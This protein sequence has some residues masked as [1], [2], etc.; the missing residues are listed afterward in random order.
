MPVSVFRKRGWCTVCTTILLVLMADLVC[1]VTVATPQDS[2]QEYDKLREE[3]LNQD[4]QRAFCSD[5]E[6]NDDELRVNAYLLEMLEEL[7]KAA[8]Q[9]GQDFP[10]A[11]PFYDVRDEIESSVLYAFLRQ[12]PKGGML[13]IHTSATGSADWIVANAWTYDG[14][15]IYWPKSNEVDRGAPK[16]A[17]TFFYGGPVPSGYYPIRD[18]REST[19]NFDA[20][21]HKL[22]TIGKE[23]ESVPNIWTEFSACFARVSGFL[24]RVDV[25]KDYY[26]DALMRLVDDRIQY[27]E[28][29][30][31][32]GQFKAVDGTPLSAEEMLD[33][34]L[35]IE[36]TVR[37]QRDSAFDLNLIISGHRSSDQTQQAAYLDEAITWHTDQRYDDFVIGYDIVGEEDPGQSNYYYVNVFL[38]RKGEIPLYFHA[39]E[40]DW[41]TDSNLFDAYLLGSQR[42]GHGFNLY[43]FQD[44]QDRYIQDDI[45]LE[46]CPIS[47]Q[48][49]R[50]I[51]DLRTHPAAGFLKNGVQ[52]TINSDDPGLLNNDG[53]SF[54]FWVATAA[55]H[56]DLRALKKLALNSLEYA[57]MSEIEKE[58]AIDTWELRWTEFIQAICDGL[59]G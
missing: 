16:G 36:Q 8:R 49:L 25:Y 40:S 45:A 22:L 37:D 23:D 29:R 1:L 48:L 35:S 41:A 9:R 47:N 15:Y 26:T 53:L 6:L 4:A 3:L 34:L 24:K 54:D 59:D 56:L 28:L 39:G 10:P 5:I 46:I 20:E 43:C 21:L 27:V 38:D 18:V 33:L 50:Y 19:P 32:I 51:D 57:G 55:W 7:E 31:G 13:H 44:L 12:M 14:C 2:S 17:L 52:C 30:A 42:V 11:V 58:S